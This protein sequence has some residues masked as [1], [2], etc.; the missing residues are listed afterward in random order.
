MYGPWGRPDTAL[1]KIVSAI[2]SSEE[3]K[4]YGQGWMRR[5]FTYAD[6][7]AEGI[8]Q[9]FGVIPEE[10][11]PVEI[12][13]ISD[14]AFSRGSLAYGQHRRPASWIDALH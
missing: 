11:K 3:I 8:I 12:E 2:E 1:F 7:L 9:L 6:D 10:G 5:D 14:T 4:V 13:Q